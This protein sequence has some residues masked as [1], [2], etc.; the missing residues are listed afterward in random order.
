MQR[1]VYTDWK[2]YVG[3]T[4]VFPAEDEENESE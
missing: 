2:E 3:D 4:P 1:S